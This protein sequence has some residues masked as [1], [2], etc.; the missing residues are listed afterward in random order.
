[1]KCLAFEDAQGYLSQIGMEVGAW[2]QISDVRSSTHEKT[3]WVRYRAPERS[4]ELYVFAQYVAGWLPKGSWK[5]FQIDNSTSLDASEA[6][7]FCR[8]IGISDYIKFKEEM[9]FRTFLFESDHGNELDSAS[10][11]LIADLIYFF[12]LFQ[13]H[14]YVVSSASIA[15]ERI[16]VQDGFAYFSARRGGISRA[17]ESI[18]DFHLNPLTSPR[19]VTA[20]M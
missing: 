13:C 19:W 18:N 10:E 16:G 11:F 15:G 8:M 3:E 4:R 1:M 12:L 7:L 5:I 9:N 20:S 14:G 6:H 2:N 17:E